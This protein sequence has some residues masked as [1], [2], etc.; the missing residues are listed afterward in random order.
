[1]LDLPPDGR[2]TVSM[3]SRELQGKDSFEYRKT[4]QSKKRREENGNGK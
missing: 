3:Y 4:G 1:M 2:L